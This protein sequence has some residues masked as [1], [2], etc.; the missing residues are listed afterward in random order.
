[1]MKYVFTFCMLFVCAA[2]F[3]Q[4]MEKVMEKRAR[5]MHAAFSSADKD[6]W[7]KFVEA[8]YSDRLIKDRG[9]DNILQMWQNIHQDLSGSK[10]VSVTQTKEGTEMI[11]KRGDDGQKATFLLIPEAASP[12]KIDRMGIELGEGP[13]GADPAEQLM[14]QLL[15]TVAKGQVKEIDAFVQAHADPKAKDPGTMKSDIASLLKDFKNHQV[16]S[17]N[18]SGQDV[19]YTIESTTTHKAKKIIMSVNANTKISAIRVSDFTH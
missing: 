17:A 14:I 6:G 10:I 19:E 12:Y 3:S 1:M 2:G 5:E 4:T 13:E 15:E 11:V 9:L 8:N 16:M 7:K 18:V